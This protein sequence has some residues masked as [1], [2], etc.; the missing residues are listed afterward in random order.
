MRCAHDF[1][2]MPRIRFRHEVRAASWDEAARRWRIE[3]SQGPFEAS[4]LVLAS[5]PLSDPV[6]PALPGLERFEGRTFHSARW[7]HGFDLA[8]KCVAV[9]GTGA[10][11]IQFVP[12]IQP[13]V[14]RLFLFQRTAPW[15]MPRFDRPI[16]DWQRRL[17][18][19]RPV[20]QRM[21]RLAFYA[22]RE[23]SV[24]FFRKPWTMRGVE[25]VGRLHRWRAVRDPALRARLKPS[26]TMGCKRILLS[27]DYY[28]A[29]TRP[30]VEL[31][32][33][34]ITE[35]RPH[36]IV[37]GDGVERSA[38][39]IIFGTGFRP[40]DIPLA[41]HV[42]G[43]H[44]RTLREVWA[45][46]PRA[47]LGTT[48][49]G[50]PNLFLLLGPN[51]GVGHTSVVY[52]IEA[53]IEHLVGALRFLQATGAVAIEPR[54]EHQQDY[55]AG[56]DRRLQGTVWLAGGCRS[57]YLDRTGRASAIWPDFTWRYARRVARFRPAEYAV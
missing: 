38:D 6:V 17:F 9:V 52:M 21:V 54:P 12:A 14:G 30:N 44:G 1:G 27:D 41:A 45:G 22:S 15:V 3:T 31:V 43:R 51:T 7:D 46:S 11:A 23:A 36:G 35:V 20:L 2:L 24:L 55:V 18:R 37:G 57:W 49:A 16:R 39:A 26:Y 56:V 28:P 48:V 33:C 40:M 19:R 47:H 25:F 5:G 4:V 32:T 34:G 53:Q 13:R 10:S 8:G 29:L 42:R 50:F